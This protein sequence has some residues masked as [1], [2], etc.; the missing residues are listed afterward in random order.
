MAK[1]AAEHHRQAADHHQKAAHLELDSIPATDQYW[2]SS[3]APVF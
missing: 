3:R 1:E 2:R